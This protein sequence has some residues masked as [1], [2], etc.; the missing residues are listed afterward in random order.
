M[1]RGRMADRVAQ[2]RHWPRVTAHTADCIIVALTPRRCRYPSRMIPAQVYCRIVRF[3]GESGRCGTGFFV[4]GPRGLS[5]VTAAHNCSGDREE[6][7]E[8]Q[9]AWADVQ[10]V[11][12]L[13][14]R[15]DAMSADLDLA[16]FD[17]PT[18]LR[19]DWYV[20]SVEANDDGLV[21]G[22]DCFI[23]GYP[24]L[25]AG[26]ANLPGT[27]MPMIKKAIISGLRKTEGVSYWFIDADANPGFSGGPL[28]FQLAGTNQYRFAGVVTGR[29]T[30]PIS[31]DG[32]VAPAGFSVCIGIEYVKPSLL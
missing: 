24:Y 5:L 26:Y 19:P 25:M 18:N 12:A 2:G 23:L 17:V 6:Y 27:G 28:V 29:M 15:C 22:Q 7:I 1:H 4:D 30:A 11:A 8:F 16:V 3:K 10:P 31:E 32:P 14:E 13:L 20:G 21:W 9:Q